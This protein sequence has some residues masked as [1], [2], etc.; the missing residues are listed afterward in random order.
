MNSYIKDTNDFLRKLRN[1]PPLQ[2]NTILCTVDVVGLYPSI[3]HDEGL[4]ALKEA[5]QERE[6]KT[7]STESLLDLTECV[8]KNN[9]FEHNS[10]YFKQ[11]QGTAIGTKM[12]PQYAILFMDHFELQFS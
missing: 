10:A 12:A 2:E 3:P 9:I 6:N 7:I 8:L 1:L 4:L 11:I 5:L